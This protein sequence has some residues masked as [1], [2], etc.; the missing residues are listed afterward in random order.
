MSFCCE[1]CV[2]LGRGLSVGL[3]TCS[4][5]ST[6]CDIYECDR[7]ALIRVGHGPKRAQNARDE[8]INLIS[9]KKNCTSE[10]RG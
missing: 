8:N 9:E 3:I 2:L 1:C 5:K 4:E 10:P 7:E 6:G